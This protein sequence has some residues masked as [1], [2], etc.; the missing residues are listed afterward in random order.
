MH[1]NDTGRKDAHCKERA[2]RA[3][4]RRHLLRANPARPEVATGGQCGEK[5]KAAPRTATR[6]EAEVS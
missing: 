1:G 6:E 5:V 3:A 2:E 4:R